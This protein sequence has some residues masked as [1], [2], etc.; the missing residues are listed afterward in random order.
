[1]IKGWDQGIK[2]MKVGGKRKLHVPASLGYGKRGALPG[3][4]DNFSI[5]VL[6]VSLTPKYHLFQKSPRTLTC[7]LWWCCKRSGSH[8][9][10][11]GHARARS[12]QCRSGLGRRRAPRASRGRV[13][14]KQAASDYRDVLASCP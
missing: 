9:R 2:G 10:D 13:R 5:C 1:M 4:T 7:T 3:K 6:S 12:S 11:R 14:I 8:F